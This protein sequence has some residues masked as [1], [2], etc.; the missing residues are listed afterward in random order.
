MGNYELIYPSER[1]PIYERIVKIAVK[2]FNLLCQ[3][4]RDKFKIDINK[5]LKLKD[6][7]PKTPK[8]QVK[9]KKKD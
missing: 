4:P 1:N 8:I 3:H 2:Q 6:K 5:K 9:K 7:G